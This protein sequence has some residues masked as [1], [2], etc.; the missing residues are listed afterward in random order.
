MNTIIELQL[1]CSNLRPFL[2]LGS[3]HHSASCTVE[4]IRDLVVKHS[5][6]IFCEF[7]QL[8]TICL[9]KFISLK[10]ESSR[11]SNVRPALNFYWT[12]N[13]RIFGIHKYFNRPLTYLFSLRRSS[14]MDSDEAEISSFDTPES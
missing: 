6:E 13:K 10:F 1:Y 2:E 3:C 11:F 7:F 5:H 8:T 12:D 9:K 4:V 14:L